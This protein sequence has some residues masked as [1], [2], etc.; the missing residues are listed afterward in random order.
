MTDYTRQIHIN[1]DPE[2]VFGTLTNAA[3]F[4]SWWAPATGS[5]QAGPLRITFDGFD[6]PLVL[7]VRQ[8]ARPSAVTWVVQ[9][10]AFLPDWVGTAPAFTLSRSG[11]G[12]CD[13]EFRHQGVTP[14]LECYE[15]CRAGWEQ[16]LPS[17]RDYLETGTGNPYTRARLA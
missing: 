13:L 15:T 3:E 17:L 6:D 5:A 2:T 10:C 1:A 9:E 4:A 7:Q 16:Y 14:Q 8:A 11:A 12:G